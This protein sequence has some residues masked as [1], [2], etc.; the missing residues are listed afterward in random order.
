MKHMKDPA[1][2]D[3]GTLAD[4]M[5]AKEKVENEMAGNDGL[6]QKKADAQKLHDELETAV[7]TTK[8]N[9]GI[10]EKEWAELKGKAEVA[11]AAVKEPL[12]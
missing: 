9:M 7:K 5:A 1:N 2:G 6:T 3:K 8:E 12:E 10:A 11:L 4:I